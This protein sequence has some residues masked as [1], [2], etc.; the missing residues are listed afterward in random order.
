MIYHSWR[1]KEPKLVISRDEAVKRLKAIRSRPPNAPAGLPKARDNSED[2]DQ[3]PGVF[4][5]M[6]LADPGF[7]G[8][9]SGTGYGSEM[10]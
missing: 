6:G 2:A 8:W 5:Q 9:I 10:W 7:K 1:V 4:N 3:I